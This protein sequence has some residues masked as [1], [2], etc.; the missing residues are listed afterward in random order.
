MYRLP[1]GRPPRSELR[2][3]QVAGDTV[4]QGE[5]DEKQARADQADKQVP[6]GRDEIVAVSFA[7]TMAQAEMC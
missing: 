2:H 1:P 3:E 7:M 4:Q 6:D 5:A